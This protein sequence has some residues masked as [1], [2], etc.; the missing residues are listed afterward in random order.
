[1]RYWVDVSLTD[2]NRMRQRVKIDTG[3]LLT[4]DQ[5][6]EFMN[7]MLAVSVGDMGK[8]GYHRKYSLK[9]LIPIWIRDLKKTGRYGLL[10]FPATEG[11]EE[12][13]TS[14]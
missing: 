7:Y 12:A 9:K 5:A 11:A 6:Q 13:I 10:H 1:M 2:V 4:P 3:L 8:L 14:S